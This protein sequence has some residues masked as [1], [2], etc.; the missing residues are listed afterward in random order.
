MG[1]NGLNNFD[2]FPYLMMIAMSFVVLYLI[3][4]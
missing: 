4:K 3:L 1:R 2:M